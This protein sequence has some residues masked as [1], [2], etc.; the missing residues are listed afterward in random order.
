MSLS[1]NIICFLEQYDIYH[2]YKIQ[3]PLASMHITEYHIDVFNILLNCF[4]TNDQEVIFVYLL[5]HAYQTVH[6]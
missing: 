3:H 5:R 4:N 2:I 6:K 1:Q